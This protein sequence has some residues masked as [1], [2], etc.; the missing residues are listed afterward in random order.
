MKTKVCAKCGKKKSRK[1]F[2]VRS[3]RSGGGAN[4][5]CKTCTN[6]YQKAYRKMYMKEHPGWN[7]KHCQS[8]QE[9]HPKGALLAHAKRRAKENGKAFSITE[10]DF[11]IPK[12]CPVLGIPLYR[13]HKVMCRN[14]PT[15][16]EVIVGRGYVEGNIQVI[17]YRANA[18]KQDADAKELLKF[19]EWVQKTYGAKR[20]PKR[21]TPSS[22]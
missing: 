10:N 8:Y 17:S 16:D 22:S 6:T 21:S 18:M 15:L 3:L 13:G 20:L 12:I 9:K 11:E 14:S 2:P 7:A 4:S 19:S 5:W 1:K